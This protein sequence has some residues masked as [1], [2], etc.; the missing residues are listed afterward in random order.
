[1]YPA[2][3][4]SI[5]RWSL[6]NASSSG[7]LQLIPTPD[8]CPWTTTDR[9]R[10]YWPFIV[11]FTT[12]AAY[13][14]PINSADG[15]IDKFQYLLKVFLIRIRSEATFILLS[16]SIGEEVK[17]IIPMRERWRWNSIIPV[18]INIF[19]FIDDEKMSTQMNK[20][21]R[22]CRIGR[23]NIDIGN[24]Y[25]FTF[26]PN[27]ECN[28]K[29]RE[30]FFQNRMILVCLSVCRNTIIIIRINIIDSEP[31]FNG[32][33]VRDKNEKGKRELHSS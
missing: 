9:K 8:G 12:L 20:L 22:I 33:Q 31:S 16:P 27:P 17:E 26:G 14:A 30:E 28:I 13:R 21:Q 32:N 5:N 18:S 19:H 10:M 23:K 2:G 4:V 6:I 3:R 15:E 1:M 7:V 24:N 29:E 11:E 25:G